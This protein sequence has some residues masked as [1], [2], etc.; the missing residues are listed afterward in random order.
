MDAYELLEG[1]PIARTGSGDE[2]PFVDAQRTGV[3]DQTIER[4]VVKDAPAAGAALLSRWPLIASAPH[5]LSTF[6]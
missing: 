3:D 5:A 2:S 4:P 1:Q 6:A